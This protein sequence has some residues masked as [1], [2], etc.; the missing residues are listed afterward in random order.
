MFGQHKITIGGDPEFFLQDHNNCFISPHK[1]VPGTK[2]D[3]TPSSAM[4]EGF[5]HVDGLAVEL[6]IPPASY[7]LDFLMSFKILIKEMSKLAQA[8]GATIVGD[9][10]LNFEQLNVPFES[11]PGWVREL[12]CDPD[13]DAYDDVPNEVVDPNTF[14]CAGGHFHVGWREPEEI[15]FDHYELCRQVAMKLDSTV[16]IYTRSLQ[17][18]DERKLLYGKAGA[19]RPKPYGIEYRTPG[20]LVWLGDRTLSVAFRLIMYTMQ[21]FENVPFIPHQRE[22]ISCPSGSGL[23][24]LMKAREKVLCLI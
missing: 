13:F 17:L 12:G 22:L 9:D 16:G 15:D 6:N 23:K 5:Y 24:A 2:H 21:N 11:L 19:F 20:N 4:P 1:F 7:S 18:E 3:P 14:R 10:I 8:H